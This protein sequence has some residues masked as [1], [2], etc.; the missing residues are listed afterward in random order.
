MHHVIERWRALETGARRYLLHLAILTLSLSFVALYYNLAVLAL[1]YSR[2]FLGILQTVTQAVAALLSLPLWLGVQRLGL[3]TAIAVS[4]A[5][6][7]A[8]ILLFAAFPQA[9][10]LVC[11]AALM[12]M[13]SVL[14]QVTAAPLM[15]RLSDDAT[16]DYLFSASAAVAI[17]L[18]GVGNLSA[19]FLA[20]AL[21]RALGVPADSGVTYRA[22]FAIAGV[23]VLA[24][25]PPLLLICEP[26]RA[27]ALSSPESAATPTD[28]D[29]LFDGALPWLGCARQWLKRLPAPLRALLR[30]P[31]L[32][33]KLLLPPFLISWGA[34]LLIP[35]LNLY[36]HERFGLDNRALG[37]LFAGF[38]IA[39]GLASLTGPALAA[40]LGK[41]RTVAVTRAIGV[42]LL[43]ILGAASDLW[44]A[45]AAAL[46]R[47]VAFNMAAP[48]YDAYAMEQTEESAR[49]FMIGL[50]GAAYSAGFL[51]A[52]LISTF[53]QERYGFGPLFAATATLYALSVVVTWWFFGKE[54]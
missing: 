22:V 20:D 48:L 36:F 16:R 24:S 14:M 27:P 3:R 5:L 40:R 8:G 44:L 25:L 23:G 2:G 53:V 46:A 50:L 31:A 43:L 13:A 19:G 42:P 12:G 30:R 28:A 47:V 6:Y 26:G 49:P 7:A 39:T 11:S 33:A 9:A 1:G 29:A 38:D 17:G 4:V 32:V 51:V 35:Y 52:P 45:I 54:R 41:M 18:S 15:M 37:A 10:L 21:G 34:A